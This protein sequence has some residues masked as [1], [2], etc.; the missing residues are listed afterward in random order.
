VA[1][2]VLIVGGASE[3]TNRWGTCQ[4]PLAEPVST[5]VEKCQPCPSADYSPVRYVELMVTDSPAITDAP[6]APGDLEIAPAGNVTNHTPTA[7]ARVEAPT[8]D[9]I[10]PQLEELGYRLE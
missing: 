6:M 9:V 3:P 7:G 4:E 1:E 5:P 8:P 10:V 2:G